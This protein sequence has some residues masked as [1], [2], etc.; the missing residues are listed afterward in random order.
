[1]VELRGNRKATCKEEDNK[2]LWVVNKAEGK[3]AQAFDVKAVQAVEEKAV[4][5]VEEKAVQRMQSG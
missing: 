5:A 4:Q 2:R 3:A 1:M